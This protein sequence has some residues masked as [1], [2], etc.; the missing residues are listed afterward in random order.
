LM[1]YACLKSQVSLAVAAVQGD[2]G[3]MIQCWVNR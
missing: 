3:A 2:W 1:K